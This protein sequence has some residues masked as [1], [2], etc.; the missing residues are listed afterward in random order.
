MVFCLFSYSQTTGTSQSH[1]KSRAWA[2][3]CQNAALN[4]CSS[5]ATH[6]RQTRNTARSVPF[7]RGS[8][9]G[10]ISTSVEHVFRHDSSAIRNT[11]GPLVWP[12]TIRICVQ[13][14]NNRW[15]NC[16]RCSQTISFA[17]RANNV[18]TNSSNN[19]FSYN[20]VMLRSLLCLL[21]SE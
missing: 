18:I 16:A 7:D 9:H 19:I 2:I 3:F 14:N 10:I 12:T 15:K 13:I 6:L 1:R 20:F 11:F 4:M 8:A 21:T 5:K 17:Y